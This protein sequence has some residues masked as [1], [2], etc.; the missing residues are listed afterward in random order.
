[1][2]SSPGIDRPLVRPSDFD[3][4]AGY[5]AKVEMRELIAGRKRYRGMLE[6]T[7]GSEL[8]IEVDLG[9]ELGKQVIGLPI[10]QVA[11]A[12]LVLTDDLI[13]EALRRA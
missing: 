2:V 4:W 6:G 13:R 9:G 3:D 12:K 11:E 10:A 1:E 7:E 5:E 8:R